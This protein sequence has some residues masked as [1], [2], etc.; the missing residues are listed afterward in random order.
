MS[1]SCITA[2]AL[3]DTLAKPVEELA[4]GLRLK[5]LTN[6][7]LQKV[8]FELFKTIKGDDEN[9]G[10]MLEFLSRLDAVCGEFATEAPSDEAVD[11]FLEGVGD[12]AGTGKRPA[13]KKRRPKAQAAEEEDDSA[14]EE[15]VV[16][17]T[18]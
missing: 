18:V 1:A 11:D 7:E 10:D 12:M 15:P 9:R 2:S 17:M 8:A 13:G 14:D 4:S 16:E 3:R 6:P 5:I